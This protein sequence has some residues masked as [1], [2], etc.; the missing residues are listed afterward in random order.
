MR[1]EKH[2]MD[3]KSIDRLV[4]ERDYIIYLKHSERDRKRFTD[5]VFAAPGAAAFGADRNL[6]LIPTTWFSGFR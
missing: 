3:E 6:H 1:K 5:M 2:R 4:L